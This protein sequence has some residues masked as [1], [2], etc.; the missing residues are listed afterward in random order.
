[1]GWLKHILLGDLGQSM[2]I[3]DTR[4]AVAGQAKLQQRQAVTLSGANRE[5]ARLKRQVEQ[6]HLALTALSRHLIDK[7]IVSAADLA[8]LAE[9]IDAADGRVDGRLPMEGGEVKPR[10]EFP[11]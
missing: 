11:G 10:L 8:E 3:E 1:M 9:R 7:R 2:D 4:D 6:L 5:I